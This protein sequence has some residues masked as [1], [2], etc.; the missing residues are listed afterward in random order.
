MVTLFSGVAHLAD[1]S[2]KKYLRYTRCDKKET[3][4]YQPHYWHNANWQATCSL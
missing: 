4:L 1:L 2:F 3:G